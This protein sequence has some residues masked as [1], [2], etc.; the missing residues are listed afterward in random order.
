MHTAM[1]ESGSLCVPM[2]SI[3]PGRAVI[4]S[5]AK[6]NAGDMIVMFARSRAK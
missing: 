6:N 5:A 2:K 4:Q 3:K 1:T